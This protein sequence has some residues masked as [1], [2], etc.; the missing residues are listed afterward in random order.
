MAEA[1]IP[2]TTPHRRRSC[3]SSSDPDDDS[4]QEEEL[5]EFL[6]DCCGGYTNAK[7]GQSAEHDP[8]W[9]KAVE[10]PAA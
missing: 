9:A 3:Q 2:T 5:P 6:H 8:T 4:P 1:P 10:E 7:Q